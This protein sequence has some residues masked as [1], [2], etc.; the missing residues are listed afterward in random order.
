MIEIRAVKSPEELSE[1]AQRC[2]LVTVTYCLSEPDDIVTLQIA[3]PKSHL[4]Y[5]FHTETERSKLI[6]IARSILRELDST[7]E[8]HE[9]MI[10]S[11]QRIES[12][13][14]DK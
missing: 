6:G 11:L 4:T 14:E 8:D 7:Y 5:V 3:A 13:L 12:F 10:A 1:N 2:E 9:S